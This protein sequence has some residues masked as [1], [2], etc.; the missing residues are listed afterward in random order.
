MKTAEIYIEQHET[1]KVEA[2][3]LIESQLKVK[4]TQNQIKV[5]RL[6]AP[7]FDGNIRMYPIFRTEYDKIMNSAY[8]KNAF[9]L[10]QSLLGDAAKVVLGVEDD[11]DEMMR[12]LDVYYGDPCKIIDCIINEIKLLEQIPKGENKEFI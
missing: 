11:Y 8:N 7:T 10:R 9:A 4:S 5:K 12:C 3:I 2:H 1:E 6:D